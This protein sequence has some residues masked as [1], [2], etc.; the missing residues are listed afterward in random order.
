[1]NLGTKVDSALVA[2]T[3]LVCALSVCLC[4]PGLLGILFT[5]F[6]TNIVSRGSVV[7]LCMCS[8]YRGTPSDC[9]AYRLCL[10]F[11]TLAPS[12]APPGLLHLKLCLLPWLIAVPLVAAV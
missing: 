12:T 4:E 1:M 8:T 6:F 11:S 5:V 9:L 3:L 2:E 10:L 7:Y